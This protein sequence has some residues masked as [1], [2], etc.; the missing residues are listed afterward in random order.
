MANADH[1]VAM[2]YLGGLHA[3]KAGEAALP[4]VKMQHVNAASALLDTAY[5]RRSDP[6]ANAGSPHPPDL[7]IL[8]LRGVAYANLP[9]FLGRAEAAR[10]C[11]EAARGH[12]AF[13]TVPS[14]HRALAYAHLA[15]LSHRGRQE[16]SA[17][18]FLEQ[19]VIA[20]AA[21]ANRIWTTR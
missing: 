18:R 10:E 12:A 7:E 14:C 21:T 11:L 5:R 9:A 6:P 8:L 15:V 13:L 2:A 16:E 1:A 17:H 19:A 20:D 3:M 4:W